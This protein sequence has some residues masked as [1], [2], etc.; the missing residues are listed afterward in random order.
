[1][2][3]MVFLQPNYKFINLYTGITLTNTV[4]EG[5]SGILL[6]DVPSM[7]SQVD[8]ISFPSLVSQALPRQLVSTLTSHS[9]TATGSSW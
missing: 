8:S 3:E 6:H 4:K 9:H 1:M 2:W 5:M 7:P